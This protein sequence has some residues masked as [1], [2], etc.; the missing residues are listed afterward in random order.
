[1]HRLQIHTHTY[2]LSH[3]NLHTCTDCLDLG[4]FTR[5]MA[6]LAVCIVSIGSQCEPIY[7]VLLSLSELCSINGSCTSTYMPG[8]MHTH[9]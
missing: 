7:L 9:A 8:I 3:P 5:V 4:Y 1:M 6:W 2:T